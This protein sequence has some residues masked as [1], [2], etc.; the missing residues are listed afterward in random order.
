M[1]GLVPLGTVVVTN[2]PLAVGPVP[3]GAPELGIFIASPRLS[4]IAYPLLQLFWC[5][6]SDAKVG[7][8]FGLVHVLSGRRYDP[9]LRIAAASFARGEFLPVFL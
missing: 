4:R 2:A 7:F 6:F 5:R 1:A 9:T 3:C 8:H